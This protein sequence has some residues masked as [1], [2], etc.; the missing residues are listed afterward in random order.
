MRLATDF[1]PLKAAI[2]DLAKVGLDGLDAPALAEEMREITRLQNQLE[3]ERVWRLSLFDALDGARTVGHRS[4]TAFLTF[5]LGL[6]PGGA[7]DR[8]RLARQ[9]SVLRPTTRAFGGGEITY[10][11][12]AIISNAAAMVD[13][14]VAPA[15]ETPIL[16]YAKQGADP[17]RL[18]HF[19]KAV[20]DGVDSAV[21]RRDAQRAQRARYFTV[22]PDRDGI[23][24]VTG[25]LDIEASA[26]LRTLLDAGTGP[27]Q[28]GDDRTPGQRRH[29]A[30]R[31][32]CREMLQGGVT[33]RRRGGRPVRVGLTATAGKWSTG[34]G[35]SV[36]LN[37]RVP[38]DLGTA[39]SMADGVTPHI[40]READS[41]NPAARSFTGA[42]RDVM[43]AG[44]GYCGW[45]L[46]CGQPA[47][48]SE[49]NHVER[50]AD[51]GETLV[52]NG[53]V[54]CRFHNQLL[55]SGWA[56]VM[57]AGGTRRALAPD[58]PQN[59][60]YVAWLCADASSQ[61]R[62]LG[63][64]ISRFEDVD[65]ATL[66]ADPHVSGPDPSRRVRAG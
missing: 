25:R 18:R 34:V 10:E 61:S 49:G 17:V 47:E 9:G 23:A 59:P 33:A 53:D 54:M 44:N 7:A 39:R 26:Y 30:L 12:A 16:E 48:W 62:Q 32:A 29:D 57:E 42:Q 35:P 37:N 15:V 6:E 27:P 60:G 65:L 14:E 40:I 46:G 31:D 43:E 58:D 11:Q 56:V 63:N 21:L 55:E 66:D 8:V 52:A 1:S 2:A 51:G 13:A 20:A 36:L 41:V 19:A 5:D 4:S 38:I 22:G 45:P 50:F 28:K 64:G 24:T 3:A